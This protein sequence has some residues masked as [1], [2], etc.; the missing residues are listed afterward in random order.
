MHLFDAFKLFIKFL[1]N[2]SVSYDT[3]SLFY[4]NKVKHV[5]SSPSVFVFHNFNN[6]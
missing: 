6:Y 1:T 2:D 3:Q 5:D 4:F